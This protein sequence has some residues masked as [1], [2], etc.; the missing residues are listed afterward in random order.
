MTIQHA[1]AK[2][3]HAS[4]RQSAPRASQSGGWPTWQR[5]VRRAIP[6]TRTAGKPAATRGRPTVAISEASSRPRT[7]C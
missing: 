2:S 3:T 6:D 4:Q 5:S 7:A 1:T